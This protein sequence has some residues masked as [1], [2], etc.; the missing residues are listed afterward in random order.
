M[1][2]AKAN[3]TAYVSKGIHSNVDRTIV[4]AVRSSTTEI[5]TANNKLDAFLKGKRVMVTIENT[6]KE[7]T[8]K[9]FIRV[10]ANKVWHGRKKKE[11]VTY[12][13]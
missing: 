9:R 13:S 2:K 6:N 5:E 11:G 1:P 7:E 4:K 3:K 12:E 8:A 10:P